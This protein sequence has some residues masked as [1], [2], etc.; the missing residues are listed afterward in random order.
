MVV[1]GLVLIDHLAWRI[2]VSDIPLYL[3][4][5]LAFDTSGSLP[6]NFSTDFLHIDTEIGVLLLLF[7]LSLEYTGEQ[8]NK[9]LKS[10]MQ[11]GLV[12]FLLH[13]PHGFLIDI[14]LGW[15]PLSA[16]VLVG[17]PIFHPPASSSGFSASRVGCT[18]REHPVLST[19]SSLRT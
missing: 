7:I 8:L 13:F 3:L 10:N 2:G 16:W 5:D 12:N 9:G 19:S 14:L 17:S 6:L 1:I 18:T 4:V 11:D 15:G